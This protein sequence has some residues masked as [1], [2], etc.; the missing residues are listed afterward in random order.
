MDT[1]TSTQFVHVR[2]AEDACE[3]SWAESILRLFVHGVG[4]LLMCLL[5]FAQDKSQE[6]R[7]TT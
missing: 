2:V 1:G 5:S 7:N 6:Q 3:V 4:D